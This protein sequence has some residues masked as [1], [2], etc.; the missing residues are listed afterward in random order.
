MPTYDILYTDSF[1][2]S[3]RAIISDWAEI[4]F[5]D[6]QIQS[7]IRIVYREI[8]LLKTFPKRFQDVTDL[9]HF[10]QVTRRLLIGR[11]AVFY[12]VDDARKMI[13]IG[14][15]FSSKQMDLRF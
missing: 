13:D 1:I 8:E 14:S 3:L 9:Y 12:R 11:Y 15:V 5:D 7:F 10:E 2:A 4:G 6:D